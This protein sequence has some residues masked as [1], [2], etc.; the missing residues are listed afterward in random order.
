MIKLTITELNGET[1]VYYV[2]TVEI[3]YTELKWISAEV[4]Y[5]HSRQL[6]EIKSYKAESR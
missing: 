1:Y 2:N 4:G 6:A 5:N 3:T